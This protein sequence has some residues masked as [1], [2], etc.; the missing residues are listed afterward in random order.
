MTIERHPDVDAALAL[1]ARRGDSAALVKL[2]ARWWSPLYRFAWNM[3]GNASLAAEVTEQSVLAA[4]RVV[5][6]PSPASIPF[7]LLTYRVAVRSTLAR[8][9]PAP[10]ARL[11]LDAAG[12]VR[13][14][15]Q[16]LDPVDRASL[17]L[18]EIEQLPIEEVEVIL[19]TSSKEIRMRTHRALF[20]LARF[21]GKA[22]DPDAP[23]LTG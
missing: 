19:K 10:A 20:F 4:I 6:P 13:K 16:R 15:L 11:P 22:I 17:V 7:M 3:S 8:E 12:S 9:T 14:A 18:L 23:P 1:E 21:A 2:A 5:E